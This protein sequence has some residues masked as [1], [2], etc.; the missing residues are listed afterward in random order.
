[1]ST[2]N[3]PSTTQL[4]VAA[5]FLLAVLGLLAGG[6]ASPNVDPA[7]ARAHTG[8]ADIYYD[9]NAALSWDIR[10]LDAGGHE[11]RTVFS[12]FD[13]IEDRILRLAF[14]PGPHRLQISFI[15]LVIAEKG[16]VD[17]EIKDGMITPVRLDFALA[18][19]TQVERKQATLGAT[20]R[21]GIGRNMKVGADETPMWRVETRAGEPLPYQMKARMPY[22]APSAEK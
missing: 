12:T 11:M 14:A 1:M 4:L 5:G 19:T 8:Y 20:I 18:G 9:T 22:Y 2:K 21:G 7:T 3:D 17:V 15:N 13:P 6:C 10:E 16:V